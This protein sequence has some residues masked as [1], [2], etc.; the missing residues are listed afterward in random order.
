[1]TIRLVSSIFV[2]QFVTSSTFIMLCFRTISI[3]PFIL[4]EYTP[5]PSSSSLLGTQSYGDW[6]Q[7]IAG[8]EMQSYHPLRAPTRCCHPPCLW[9]GTRWRHHLR[10][11]NKNVASIY[12]EDNQFTGFDHHVKRPG[13]PGGGR[14]R[15]AQRGRTVFTY[16][17]IIRRCD[18]NIL[19]IQVDR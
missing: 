8:S 7:D 5:S 17:G 19:E 14:G 2:Q 16:E 18:S 13:W 11:L 9:E 12:D 3:I 15:G 4:V 1:M 10:V 6:V